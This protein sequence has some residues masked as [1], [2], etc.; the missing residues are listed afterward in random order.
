MPTG[1][2]TEGMNEDTPAVPAAPPV[3]GLEAS[4]AATAGDPVGFEELWAAFPRKHQRA[5]A[6]AEYNALAPD[7]DLHARLVESALALAAHHTAN[8]T[9]KRWWKHLHTWLIEERYLEDL[10]E[11]Y[12]NAKDAAIARGSRRAAAGSK[13]PATGKSGLSP[14][15]PLG[16]H[17]VVIIGTD[18][19][20][21]TLDPE[22]S[23]TFSYRIQGGT[24]DGKEFSHTFKCQS[25]N[26]RQQDEGQS[27]YANIRNATGK[28]S[29]DDLSELHNMP[30]LAIVSGMGRIEYGAL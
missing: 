28:F 8:G 10:P 15:T 30:L 16:R 6:R 26:G 1:M 25:E 23:M 13:T 7:H 29:P 24:H 22:Q 2:L 21:H 27:F 19:P 12:E 3:S 17:E 14:K 20:D 18:M 4:T 9:E 11:P 5:K